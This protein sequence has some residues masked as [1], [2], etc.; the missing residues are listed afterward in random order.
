M[1]PQVLAGTKADYAGFLWRLHAFHTPIE[2]ALQASTEL[3]AC[4]PDL[5]S[6]RR[7]HLAR[8]DLAFLNARE[9]SARRS[10][11]LPSMGDLGEMV[12]VAYV[13]E[14]A[15][16]GGQVLSRSLRARFGFR[17]VGALYLNAYGAKTGAMWKAFVNALAARRWS[18]R[19]ERD[20]G[21]AATQTF[22]ALR[23]WLGARR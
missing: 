19:E 15:T 18:E 17:D 23:A 3:G 1:R 9:P 12:G 14:G 10:F 6:R 7:V 5:P 22:L 8:E 21:A 4:I 2:S 16:L 11:E 13:F 20:A